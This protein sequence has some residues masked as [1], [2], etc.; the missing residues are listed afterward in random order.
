MF[1]HLGLRAENGDTAYPDKPESEEEE[2]FFA[3]LKKTLA[4]KPKGW[5]AEVAKNIKGVSE[6][7]TTGVQPPLPAGRAG[8]AAGPGDQRERFRHQVEV[9][10]PLRLPRDP[11]R[12]IRRA[13]PTS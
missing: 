9:R 10:Q 4:A 3:L 2:I 12:R 11:G 8:Q 6:E 13:P 5:F 1:V 7:T